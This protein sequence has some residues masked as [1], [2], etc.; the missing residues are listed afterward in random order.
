MLTLLRL[1][2][3]LT[4]VST[5]AI[6][7]SDVH[8]AALPYISL[9][10]PNSP[11][12]NPPPTT[13]PLSP[14]HLLILS[15]LPT[16]TLP[17]LPASFLPWILVAVGYI[18]PIIFH[19][20]FDFDI[21][22]SFLSR[23]APGPGGLRAWRAEIERR[24]LT[25]RLDDQIAKSEIRE[26]H[27]WE[28]ERLDP[29]WLK[30]TVSK[31]IQGNQEVPNALETPPGFAWSGRHLKPTDK[32]PWIRALP[33][34]PNESLWEDEPVRVLEGDAGRVSLTL[35]SG[36]SFV[37]NEEWRVDYAASWAGGA[38]DDGE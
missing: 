21:I 2:K 34:N 35:V 29:T 8:D 32:Q 5:L 38:A 23:H 24:L 22:R 9:I 11:N 17:L 12:P 36:W 19:P 14:T 6:L 28:N 1:P 3:L 30:N 26:V 20:N 31:V 37:P 27:V 15:L 25:D 13:F 10:S 33:R 4:L 7:S 16:L 18:P